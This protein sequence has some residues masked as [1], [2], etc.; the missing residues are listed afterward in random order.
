MSYFQRYDARAPYDQSADT[1]ASGWSD[2]S[3]RVY[4][5]E[6]E[7]FKDRYW[8]AWWTRKACFWCRRRGPVLR[9]GRRGRLDLNHLHLSLIH[10]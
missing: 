6:W 3:A 4:G 9:D 7:I 2:W 1:A 5:P 8:A 10:I